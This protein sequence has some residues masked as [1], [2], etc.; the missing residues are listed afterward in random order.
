MPCHLRE[1]ILIFSFSV[2]EYSIFHEVLILEVRLHPAKNK[3]RIT[4]F[5]SFVGPYVV[6]DYA[7]KSIARFEQIKN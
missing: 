4:L 5:I 2:Q 1:L 6:K 3:I 7:S